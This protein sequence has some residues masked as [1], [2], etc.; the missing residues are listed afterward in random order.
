MSITQA[1]RA[2][3]KG[4]PRGKPFTVVHFRGLGSRSTVSRALSRLAAEGAITRVARGIFVRPKVNRYIGPVSPATDEVVRAIAQKTGETIQIH[5]AD[6]ARRF[7][8]STQMPLFPIYNTN[9]SSRT[10]NLG[11]LSVKLVHTTNRR[12]LQFA[13]KPEGLALAALWY[14]GKSHVTPETV[15]K[16]KEGLSPAEFSNLSSADIPAWMASALNAS[17]GEAVHA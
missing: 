8:L 1:V 6:A 5:G 10:L 14:F 16:I 17:E 13:G 15:A 9:G 11:G 2:S 4:I 7:K 3:T 12:L